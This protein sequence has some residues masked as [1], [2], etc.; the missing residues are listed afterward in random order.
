M[1]RVTSRVTPV[2][3]PRLTSRVMVVDDECEKRAAL[4][5]ALVSEGFDAIAIGSA[6]AVRTANEH[7]PH[8]AIV[9]LM[10]HGTNGFEL[11]RRLREIAP[12]VGVILTSDYHFSPTQLD[13]M[14]C[15]A[16]AFVPRP[17]ALAELAVFL[18]A[19]L[20]ARPD[21]GRRSLATGA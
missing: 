1:S 5:A 18:R 20:D 10:L 14:D 19:K 21:S 3:T 16:I 15:G 9:D 13:R 7:A 8:L 11:A 2:V 17:F 12:H 6:D 4:C